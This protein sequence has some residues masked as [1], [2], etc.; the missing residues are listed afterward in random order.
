MFKYNRVKWAFRKIFLP[1]HKDGLVLDVGSGGTPYPRSDVLLDRLT[2]SEHRCGDSMMLDRLAV[3][4]DAQKMPFKD[5]S[6]DF[7]VASHILEHMA[8][9]EKFITELQRVGKAGYI[10]TPNAIFE[11]LRPY[12]IHCLEVMSVD[13][14]LHIH[15]KKQP[16]EDSYLG[17]IE[18]LDKDSKWGKL[19]FERLDM[20]HV[21]FFWDSE[22]K[23]QVHNPEVSCDWIENINDD[24]QVGEGKNSYLNKDRGWRKFG[25]SILNRW[26]TFQRTQRL[27]NFDLK[28]ILCCPEC[29]DN[30]VSKEKTLHC[31]S[32]N[33][34]YQYDETP[35]FTMHDPTVQ[36]LDRIEP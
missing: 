26:Y 1:V 10:E 33:V 6:F 31:Q 27:K 24:S 5:K 3:F 12:N 21:R 8:E 20:F 36:T 18:F 29:H 15:K 35:D 32:C 9:P 14:I 4:G 17:A 30:L 7:I 19:F 16:V 2:G 23:F 25:L 13:G 11:R 34:T 28:N 22:I